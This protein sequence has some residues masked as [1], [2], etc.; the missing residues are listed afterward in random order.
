MADD[1]EI[2]VQKRR[3]AANYGLLMAAHLQLQLE[4]LGFQPTG[5]LH[6]PRAAIW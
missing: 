6:V 2:G 5:F 3:E 4:A 1:S